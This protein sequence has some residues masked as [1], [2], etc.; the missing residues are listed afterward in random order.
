MLIVLL[1]FLLLFDY[2]FVIFGYVCCVLW[3]LLLLVG[4]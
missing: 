1:G 3:S 4:W 2:L